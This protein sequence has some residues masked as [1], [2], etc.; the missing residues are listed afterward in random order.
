MFEKSNFWLSLSALIWYCPQILFSFGECSK[1]PQKKTAE[2]SYRTEAQAIKVFTSEI[3][4]QQVKQ[5]ASFF[6]PFIKL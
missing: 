6:L 1:N 5:V 4:Q 2:P 3:R